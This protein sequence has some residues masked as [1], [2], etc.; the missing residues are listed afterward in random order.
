MILY[1]QPSAGK[2]FVVLDLIMSTA[3]AASFASRFKIN[4]SVEI[5]YATGEKLGGLPE[6]VRAARTKHGLT[7][8][9]AQ[10]IKL[11]ERVP[12]LYDRNDVD[13]FITDIRKQYPRGGLGL[14][15]ID[16]LHCATVGA[17]ENDSKDAGVIISNLHRIQEALGCAVILVH[18][19]TKDG[20]DLRGSSA[21]SGSADELIE[22][23]KKGHGAYCLRAEKVG[24]AEANF[25]VNF[26]LV[27][28]DIYPTVVVEW[29]SASSVITPSNSL[30]DAIFGELAKGQ[31]MTVKDLVQ[32]LPK[33]SYTDG[34][35]SH[36]AD[37]LVE[38]RK[39]AGFQ[40]DR[41]LQFPER[42]KSNKN[43]YL[44]SVR[45]LS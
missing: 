2:T 41:S 42:V 37:R 32:R 4:T 39:F 16:T 28:S 38:N 10:D 24:D 12:Q 44:Y 35:I 36:A 1:G 13:E 43:R 5:L 33:G 14:L 21:F 11:M 9:E 23:S 25:S 19:S 17:K 8:D 3:R 34:A 15:V 27:P 7:T 30:R 31:P 29:K 45:Q 40:I 26:S 18:H 6:R 22:I 20:S